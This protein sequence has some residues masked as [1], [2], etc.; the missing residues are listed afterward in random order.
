MPKVN[1]M[2]RLKF[3]APG[4]R[5]ISDKSF[6]LNRV[7]K[8]IETE[9]ENLS[10]TES[11]LGC[12]AIA[13]EYGDVSH[14]GP[15]YPDVAVMARQMVRKSINALDSINLPSPSRDKVKEEFLGVECA[16][17]PILLELAPIHRAD[18]APA[19]RAVMRLHRR[20]YRRAAM[21]LA[22]SAA[23][24]VVNMPG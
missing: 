9:R 5:C 3:R 20:H 15:Y 11:L 13:M 22:S 17:G 21:N 23:S 18:L 4:E 8:A 14:E 6:H 24:A 19:R 16:P 7:L 12:L 2:K 1:A 10:R